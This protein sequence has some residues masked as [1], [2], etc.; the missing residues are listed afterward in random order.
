[1]RN[2]FKTLFG[3]KIPSE[4]EH[5]IDFINDI[6]SMVKRKE[7]LTKWARPNNFEEYGFYIHSADQK[8]NIFCG[9]WFDLW[10]TKGSPFCICLDWNDEVGLMRKQ[11]FGE[12][13]KDGE[14]DLIEYS[15]YPTLVFKQDYFNAVAD[16]KP[17]VDLIEQICVRLKFNLYFNK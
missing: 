17:I 3:T 16:E 9:L 12:F 4:I 14:I 8:M 10:L 7:V 2:E 1:M 13:R 15:E 5:L 6:R 11:L